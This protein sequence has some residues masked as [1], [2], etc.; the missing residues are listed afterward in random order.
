VL[1]TM[2]AFVSSIGLWAAGRPSCAGTVASRRP[3]VHHVR[4][5]AETSA[6]DAKPAVAKPE[7][8]KTE[9]SLP[10]IP[11]TVAQDKGI[12]REK[13]GH[14][15]GKEIKTVSQALKEFNDSFGR[16]VYS[17]YSNV[18]NDVIATTHLSRVCAAFRYDAIFAFGLETV[19]EQF[20]ATYPSDE[21][22]DL[23]RKCILKS[24]DFKEEEIR[25]DAQEVRSWLA[26]G[27][28][29]DDVLNAATTPGTCKVTNA[30]NYAANAP[31]FEWY[32]SRMYAIGLFKILEGVGVTIDPEAIERVGQKL[33]ISVAKLQDEYAV[34]MGAI[35]KMKAAETLFAEVAARD[36]RK[37]AERLAEKAE[38]MKAEAEKEEKEANEADKA[39]SEAEG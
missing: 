8:V 22:R 17:I 27:K 7:P 25:S 21:E 18:V 34:Y 24:L 38:Q 29:E 13:Y 30:I 1:V 36:K 26:L 14:L 15:E 5:C 37:I 23:L 39:G 6:A 31:F 33:N 16:P 10:V 3:V 2:N 28:T 32:F 9:E 19:F 20:F 4:L 35:E 11:E 12:L